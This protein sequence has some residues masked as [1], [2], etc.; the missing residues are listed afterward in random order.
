MTSPDSTG[1][2]RKIARVA[3]FLLERTV[4]LPLPEAWRRLTEW[5]R[6]ADVVPLTRV[7][8]T[9]PEPTHEGTRF[10]ARS[11]LGPLSFEDP[12]EVTVWQPPGD[13]TPGR[14]R[15]EKRGRVITGWAEIEV[16]P[17]PGGRARVVWREELRVRFVPGVLDGVVERAARYVFGRA[18]NRLLRRA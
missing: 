4:P 16:R 13:D 1:P 10:V 7:R 18:M 12:M 6:H 2:F 17:G 15:L 5:P 3:N 14:C 8:V 11:G 9:T